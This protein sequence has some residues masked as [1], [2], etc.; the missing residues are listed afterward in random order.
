MSAP[1]PSELEKRIAAIRDSKKYRGQNI[2]TETLQNLFDEEMKTGRSLK[3]AD[4]NVRTKLHNIMAPYLGDPDYS[5]ATDEISEACRSSDRHNIRAVCAKLLDSHAS[6]R[7]RL[8]ILTEFYERIFARIGKPAS[9]LDLACGLN[10]FAFPWMGLPLTTR[11]IAFDIHQPRVDLI[12][13]FFRG[14]GMEALTRH[15]DILVS[16][17]EEQAD[18]AFFFK[19]AHRFEQRQHGCNLAM[20]QA[21][22]VR[23]VLVSLPTSSLSRKFDLADRQRALVY[24]ILKDQRWQ[25]EEIL[26]DTELV[27]C[28]DKSAGD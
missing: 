6:T 8:P 3:Q 23:W 17:P 19:E 10:P 1:S 24:G 26:V 5:C 9:I 20:W 18:T 7:E 12:N 15:Q 11:Y 4:D 16:P 28:I 14:L 21:L 2:P 25:V 22:R 13:H 27:F